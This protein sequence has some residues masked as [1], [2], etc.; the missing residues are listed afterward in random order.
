MAV[1][2]V[3]LQTILSA[4]WLLNT[5]RRNS[6]LLCAPVSQAQLSRACGADLEQHL[7]GG[8]SHPIRACSSGPSPLTSTGHSKLSS[9][10]TN[11]PKC[12][13]GPHRRLLSG[14]LPRE[15]KEEYN[16]SAHILARSHRSIALGLYCI[17]I[18][19]SPCSFLS[20]LRLSTSKT[21]KNVHLFLLSFQLSGITLNSQ[22]TVSDLGYLK[23]VFRMVWNSCRFQ[24]LSLVFLSPRKGRPVWSPTQR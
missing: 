6:R 15:G 14:K 9:L 1:Q 23:L 13:T 22:G 19:T 7:Q 24:T 17:P 5:E 12:P 2:N 16:Y 11:F 4:H 21:V 8:H 10:A 20:L 18:P 3:R